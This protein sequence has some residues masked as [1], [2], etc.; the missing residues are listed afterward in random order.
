[1]VDPYFLLHSGKEEV[2]VRTSGACP[3]LMFSVS[4]GSRAGLPRWE[5]AAEAGRCGEVLTLR[6]REAVLSDPLLR[7]RK[8][9]SDLD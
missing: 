9:W 6:G 7:K 5:K 8:L 3:V 1:M 4:Q 2:R